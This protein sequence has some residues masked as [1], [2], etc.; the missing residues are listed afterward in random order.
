[1]FLVNTNDVGF[2]VRLISVGSSIHKFYGALKSQMNRRN[3][4]PYMLVLVVDVYVITIIGLTDILVPRRCFVVGNPA[5]IDRILIY[6]FIKS[7]SIGAA[8]LS[9]NPLSF[10]VSGSLTNDAAS[11]SSWFSGTEFVSQCSSC[12]IVPS[13]IALP[14]SSPHCTFDSVLPRVISSK[15]VCAVIPVGASSSSNAFK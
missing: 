14:V 11:F 9:A 8:S 6:W 12:K 1:M 7:S 3:N 2:D 15:T 10:T 13:V 4:V 5:I